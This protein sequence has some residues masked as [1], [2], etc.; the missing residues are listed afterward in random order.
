MCIYAYILYMVLV[1]FLTFFL[2]LAQSNSDALLLIFFALVLFVYYDIPSRSTYIAHSQ[3]PYCASYL[4][5]F[6][7]IQSLY[8]CFY[9]HFVAGLAM[10][11]SFSLTFY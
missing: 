1:Y 10:L 7:D 9:I 5:F 3:I 11:C 8:I 2:L 6:I 4:L